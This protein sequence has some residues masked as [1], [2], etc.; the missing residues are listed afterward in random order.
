MNKYTKQTGNRGGNTKQAKQEY[1][2]Q[3]RKVRISSTTTMSALALQ[4]MLHKSMVER[5]IQHEAK[6]KDLDTMPTCNRC[7]SARV[8]AVH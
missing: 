1:A 3:T 6:L 8:Q 7:D 4:E 5:L 2:Q